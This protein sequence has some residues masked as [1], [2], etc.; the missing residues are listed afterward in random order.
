M[1][2]KIQIEVENFGWMPFASCI[3]NALFILFQDPRIKYTLQKE[4][5]YLV[6]F[7]A[8]LMAKKFKLNVITTMNASS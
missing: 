6:K 7:M 8:K 5:L 4:D 2:L 1:K 3:P